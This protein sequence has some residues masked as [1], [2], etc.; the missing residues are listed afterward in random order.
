MDYQNIVKVLNVRC[1]ECCKP[2]EDESAVVVPAEK[3]PEVARTLR[4][5]PDLTFDSLMC[6]T[7]YDAGDG[8]EL[9]VAYNFYSMTKGHSLEIRILV[10]VEN[11][12]IP[13]VADLWRAADWH[14]R[15]AFDMFGIEFTG[16]P[17]L[18]RILLPD[19]WEGY[20]L[21]KDF[22]TPEY[23]QGIKIEKDKSYWE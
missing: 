10:P 11:P 13:S 23:Y 8:K 18:K 14:E 7:G 22:K 5:D 20:P 6:L 9:G 4:N 3:W 19:D 16:H 15:E 12:Q 21:R 1:A 17:D 2:L